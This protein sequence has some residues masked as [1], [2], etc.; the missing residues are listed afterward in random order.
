MKNATSYFSLVLF[1]ITA[2]M[3]QSCKIQQMDTT[4]IIA[5]NPNFNQ[6]QS[7]ATELWQKQSGDNEIDEIIQYDD[8]QILVTSVKYNQYLRGNV[9]YYKY[10]NLSMLNI[11]NGNVKWQCPTDSL[12]QQQ[13]EIISLNPFILI[14]STADTSTSFTAVDPENGNIRWK[15]KTKGLKTTYVFDKNKFI[16]VV[17]RTGSKWFMDCIQ[18]KEGSVLWSLP[19]A[20]IEANT[21]L[22]YI[23]P[24]NSLAAVI[25]NNLIAIDSDKGNIKWRK[26]IP[27]GISACFERENKI[28]CYNQNKI[29]GFHLSD[30]TLSDEMDAKTGRIEQFA[31]LADQAVI[32]EL[33]TLHQNYLFYSKNMT[34]KKC[35][36][37][38]P[39]GSKLN[40]ILYFKNNDLLFTTKESFYCIDLIT[41]EE[42][43]TVSFNPSSRI[44]SYAMD[45]II[46]TDQY[47]FI[48]AEKSL[49]KISEAERKMGDEIF[50]GNN[51]GFTP[52]FINNKINE[53]LTLAGVC[54]SLPKPMVKTQLTND[55]FYNM[56][57]QNQAWVNYT[58]KSTVAVNSNASHAQKISAYN[59]RGLA[60]QNTALMGETQAYQNLANS[61]AELGSAVAMVLAELVISKIMN[62]IAMAINHNM[63]YMRKNIKTFVK[64]QNSVCSGYYHLRPYYHDGWNI[65]IYDIRDFRFASIPLTP[66]LIPY[67]YSA[68]QT[69]PLVF[70]QKGEKKYLITKTAKVSNEATGTY[71][72]RIMENGNKR[73]V[74][75]TLPKPSVVCYDI[76]AQQMGKVPKIQ[77]ENATL[78]E[79]EKKLVKA[80][81]TN[82]YKELK[83]LIKSGVNVNITDEYGYTLLMEVCKR[84]NLRLLKMLLKAGADPT[85]KDPEGKDAAYHILTPA[86]KKSYI[87]IQELA[88]M[89]KLLEKYSK[90]V[91]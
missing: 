31:M 50:L 53:W 4:R 8:D 23:I 60:A 25:G 6:P 73:G 14:C 9:Y 43:Y 42:K 13:Q 22:S 38:K 87:T 69:Y 70:I 19:I 1:F 72:L 68:I 90:K 55:V 46:F 45:Q 88:K 52:S 86:N 39:I 20:N 61:Y 54:S 29:Y 65:G 18:L 57:K 91:K 58:T 48:S 78:S 49:C 5:E 40:S 67:S 81:N 83:S 82:N 79:D 24:G 30:G 74:D 27:Q 12:E 7:G 44:G 80:C 35:L 51:G 56:A 77:P 32:F 64:Y 34:D 76:S 33:D 41:G 59:Q 3:L 10:S 26:N 63:D 85:I 84:P 16:Y 2:I 75:Y 11:G 37:E 89:Y 28:W 71:V 17:F 66:E 62:H 21:F 15:Y 36:W 47:L